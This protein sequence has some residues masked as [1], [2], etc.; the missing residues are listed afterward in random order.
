MKKFI[1]DM[2]VIIMIFMFAILINY[3]ISEGAKERRDALRDWWIF[4]LTK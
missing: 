3:C 4:S 2:I 1:E